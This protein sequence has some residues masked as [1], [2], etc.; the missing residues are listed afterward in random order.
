MATAVTSEKKSAIKEW[1]GWLR[2][3]L[4]S[5]GH[6][7]KKK[8]PVLRGAVHEKHQEGMKLL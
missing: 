6:C 4:E 2:R 8:E 5:V 7:V 1:V 3:E